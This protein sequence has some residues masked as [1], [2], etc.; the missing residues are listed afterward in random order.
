M[1][2][3]KQQHQQSQLSLSAT[4]RAGPFAPRQVLG[5]PLGSSACAWRF[6]P[7]LF[8]PT[9]TR[10]QQSRSR[11]STGR[12]VS[13]NGLTRSE[14][15]EVVRLVICSTSS[16]VHHLKVSRLL[17]RA[18]NIYF[19]AHGTNYFFCALALAK[20]RLT[21]EEGVW[22]RPSRLLARSYGLGEGF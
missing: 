16:K 9:Q 11:T 15:A 3:A 4:Q 20:R 21:A 8:R 14:V 19:L 6:T 18:D 13:A 7:S 10:V 1:I 12:K 22:L 2:N 5:S 17:A